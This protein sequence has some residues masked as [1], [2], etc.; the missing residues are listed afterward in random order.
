MMYVVNLFTVR[1][2]KLKLL[3]NHQITNTGLPSKQGQLRPE[4]KI[5]FLPPSS[6]IYSNTINNQE[7]QYES[8]ELLETKTTTQ[9]SLQPLNLYDLEATRSI[10]KTLNAKNYNY[11]YKKILFMKTLALLLYLIMLGV[12]ILNVWKAFNIYDI[13]YAEISVC[14]IVF[15]STG[16]LLCS[17]FIFKQ[18]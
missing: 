9:S 5:Y 16:F 1:Y 15:L 10:D 18:K 8:I 11:N 14:S 7:N 17:F 13:T 2:M 3:T 12:L 4:E 6:T